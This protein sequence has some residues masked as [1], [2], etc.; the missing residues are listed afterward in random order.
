MTIAKCDKVCSVSSGKIA[1]PLPIVDT[2]DRTNTSSGGVSP[3]VDYD[4]IHQSMKIPPKFDEKVK[5]RSEM[6]KLMSSFDVILA[7]NRFVGS[8]VRVH[9]RK[10]RALATK[11]TARK[12]VHKR[13]NLL[14]R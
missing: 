10:R 9:T 5:K 13:A 6:M 8:P 7:F 14:C 2:P 12:K 4:I 3:L 1:Q 11:L